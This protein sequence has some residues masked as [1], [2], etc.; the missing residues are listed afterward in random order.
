MPRR[1]DV[2]V[3]DARGAP[4]A[5]L[6]GTLTAIRPADVRLRDQAALVSVPGQAGL[7]RL[8]LRLPVGGLWVFELDANQGGDAYRVVLRED[9]R[10]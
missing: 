1:V 7:Y 4:V 2:R 3:S 9:V 5:G 6:S 8:L 10:I